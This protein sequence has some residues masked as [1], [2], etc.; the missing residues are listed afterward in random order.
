MSFWSNLDRLDK[1]FVIWA[2]LF[3]GILIVHFAIRKPLFE[4]YT[5][6]YGWLVYALC[7][8]AVIVSVI[9]ILGGKDWTYWLGGFLFLI[10][11]V[12]GYWV[13]FVSQTPFRNPFQPLIG[14]PYVILYLT[15]VMFYWWPLWPLSKLLWGIYTI[16]YVV[17]SILNIRSH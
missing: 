5:A 14:I 4:S 3:Q 16:L 7:I 1:L 6:K 13:D 8:P 15:T 17:A 12:F 9:L 10:Y 2:F 11:A